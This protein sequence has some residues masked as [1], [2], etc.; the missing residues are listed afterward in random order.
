MT[1]NTAT[2]V[3]SNTATDSLG[4]ASSGAGL[5][6]RFALRLLLTSYTGRGGMLTVIEGCTEL[7][8]GPV[9]RAAEWPGPPCHSR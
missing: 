1:S 3:I 8:S 9:D 7:G 2:D 5:A 6:K 4:S